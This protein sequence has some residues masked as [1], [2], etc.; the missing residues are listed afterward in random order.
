MKNPG[1]RKKL[2]GSVTEMPS[3]KACVHRLFFC[4]ETV[5]GR[6]GFRAVW[7]NPGRLA[8]GYLDHHLDQELQNE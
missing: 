8:L 1:L 2:H 5:I 6:Y 4:G 3:K 7:R